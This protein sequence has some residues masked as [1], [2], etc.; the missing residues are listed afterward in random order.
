MLGRDFHVL[1]P[2]VW[3]CSARETANMA[4]NKAQLAAEHGE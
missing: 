4:K 1:G 3:R 2:D